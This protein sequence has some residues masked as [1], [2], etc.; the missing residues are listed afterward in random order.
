MENHSEAKHTGGL[1]FLYEDNHLLAVNKRAGDLVQADKECSE[2]LEEHIKQYIKKRD[3]KAGAVF[4]GVPHRLDRPVSGIV[5][6]AKTSKALVRL[7][8]MFQRGDVHKKYWAIVKPCPEKEEGDLTHYLTR[9][10]QQHK[11]YAHTCFVPHSK[12]ARLHYRLIGRSER[13]FL[14]EIELLTG[15]HHQI[16][17]QL[18]KIGSPIKGDLKYGFPR[19]NPNGGISLHARSIEFV[20]PVSLQPV[21][22]VAPLPEN[23]IF[24]KFTI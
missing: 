19:S 13:Y 8:A 1:S 16:R 10:E 12:Q 22:V 4:L 24:E 2:S 11:T 23:D 9:N 17:C 18:S 5:V 21:S 15:R 20:H 14:L 7:N 6:F 3:G